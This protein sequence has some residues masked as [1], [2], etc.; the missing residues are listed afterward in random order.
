MRSFRLDPDSVAEFVRSWP[1]VLI[2]ALTGSAIAFFGRD[3]W[4]IRFLLPI[5]MG[6]CLGPRLFVGRISERY[7]TARHPW[8][9]SIGLTTALL[10]VVLRM[11]VPTWRGMAFDLTW[12]G[13]SFFSI[14]AFVLLNR[15]NDDVVR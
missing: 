13:V 5:L 3:L 12:L 10:G 4:C 6:V 8:L 14:L 11:A 9:V 15:G 7:P 2:G 1:V